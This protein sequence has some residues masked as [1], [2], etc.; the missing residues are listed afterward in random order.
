MHGM[1]FRGDGSIIYLALLIGLLVGVLFRFRGMNI[2]R[3]VNRF[4]ITTV[5]IL[6]LLIGIVAGYT[7]M[8]RLFIIGIQALFILLTELVL[9]TVLPIVIGFCLSLLIAR[10]GRG[11]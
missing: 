7:I 5:F 9:L 3:I 10:T 1:L 6:V 8:A 4:V 11:K 2:N